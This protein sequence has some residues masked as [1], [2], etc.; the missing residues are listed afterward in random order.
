MSEQVQIS[1]DREVYDQLQ[2]LMV[3]PI[4]DINAAIRSLLYHE[5]R[6]SEAALAAKAETQHFSYDQELER[7]KL[8]VYECGGA[9]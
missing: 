4:S 5:G 1:L 8:G 6:I 2:V 7:A 9:T 3:P